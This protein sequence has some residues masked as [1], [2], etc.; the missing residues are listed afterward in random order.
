MRYLRKSNQKKRKDT[1]VKSRL[2]LS[3]HSQNVYSQAK[4]YDGFANRTK[5]KV[6][7]F[8]PLGEPLALQARV[9]FVV[10]GRRR[11]I[12]GVAV[13]SIVVTIIGVTVIAVVILVV[14]VVVVVHRLD[15]Q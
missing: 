1:F 10:I 15:R 9:F 5:S 2:S 12:G 6:L 7:K 3:Y 14:V 11:G 4:H 13:I 8:S